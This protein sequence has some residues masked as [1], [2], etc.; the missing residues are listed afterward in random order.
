MGACCS[1]KEVVPVAGETEFRL[2]KTSD[3]RRLK[4]EESRKSL[5]PASLLQ[6]DSEVTQMKSELSAILSSSDEVGAASKLKSLNRKDI[7]ARKEQTKPVENDE[8]DA[9]AGG[10]NRLDSLTVSARKIANEDDT[11]T[12]LASSLRVSSAADAVRKQKE[13]EKQSAAAHAEVSAKLKR[14]ENEPKLAPNETPFID[15]PAWLAPPDVK[16]AGV[17]KPKDYNLG[18]LVRGDHVIETRGVFER[19]DF[20]TYIPGTGPLFNGPTPSMMEGGAKESGLRLSQFGL[21]G[22]LLLSSAPNLI[23]IRKLEVNGSMQGWLRILFAFSCNILSAS[24]TLSSKLGLKRIF[25]RGTMLNSIGFCV[26]LGLLSFLWQTTVIYGVS[27]LSVNRG[28]FSF[29]F[30]FVAGWLAVTRHNLR[31]TKRAELDVVLSTFLEIEKNSGRMAELM[32][33]PAVRTAEMQF[34]NAAPV[35][36]RYRPDELVPWL[37]N[38]LTQV[39]PFYNKAVSDMLR[40][41]L[42]P[43]MEASRPSMLK[44]LTFKQLDFGSNPFVVRNIKYVGKK[45]SDMATSIDIDFAWAGKS[46]IVLAAKTHIGADIN[47]A[48]KDLEIYSNLRVTMNPLVPLPSP[49]GGLVISMTQRPVVEF[50]VE[51][52]TGL[53]WLYNAIDKWLE[54]FVSDLLGDMFIQ[55]ER[56]IVPLSFNYDPIVMPDGEVKPFKWYDTQVL[57]LRSTGV[58]KVTVV[59]AE[60]V[61]KTDM[62]SKTDPYVQMFVKKHGVH[63][64]TTTKTNDEDPVWEETFYIPVDDVHL[65]KLKVNVFDSDSDPFSS[66]ERLAVAELNIDEIK[67][68]TA[69]ESEQTIWVDFPEQ[70][71]GNVKKPPMRLLLNTQ[72]IMFGSEAAKDIFAGLGL[73]TVHILRGVNLQVMD[74]NGLSDP[75]VKVKIPVHAMGAGVV[76]VNT[77]KMKKSSSKS[78]RKDQDY[79]VYTS[80]IHYKTL[81]PEFNAKFEFSPTSEDAKV[82]IEL[83]D[84]DQTFPV[85]KKSN[86]MGNL[87]VPITT[88]IQ[89][90]GSMEARFKIG[91]AKSGELDI[92][93]DWQPYT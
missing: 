13:Q 50:H 45:G 64:K 85:G 63:V 54:E 73:L 34:M 55:P 32:G 22:I 28:I 60:N 46:N 84:V 59:R 23:F 1:K 51:L 67:D 74:S 82:L 43:L 37:N 26:F 89:H 83:Y 19:A 21:L 3:G 71:K 70:V 15:G 62:F 18:D 12:D 29:L 69:D 86:F 27:Y 78:K 6:N 33:L 25:W 9:L 52:P 91:N 61:P 31:L 66:D 65:R 58:L 11:V 16:K 39:W 80:K 87:E 77:K 14:Y 79:V 92:A 81:N 20:S 4:S 10:L 90:G 56:L 2:R 40:E 17:Q 49:I 35:W 44:R 24:L 48:V 88:V 36:A 5:S 38:F 41:I 76:P 93:F 8:D 57:Q 7:K 42:D 72:F 53:E 30:A 75:Y 68:A 47:I